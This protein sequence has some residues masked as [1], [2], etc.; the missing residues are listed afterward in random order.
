MEW[1][2]KNKKVLI[3]VICGI[4]TTLV[5][6]VTYWIFRQFH[7]PYVIANICSW[8]LAVLFAYGTNKQFVFQ[9]PW[10]QEI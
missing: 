7:M 5:D 4:G 6:W 10:N 8:L 3:Y 1:I 2:Q 9:T